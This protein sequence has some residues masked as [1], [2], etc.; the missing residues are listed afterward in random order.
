MWR[1]SVRLVKG[2]LNAGTMKAFSTNITKNTTQSTSGETLAAER[3]FNDA[4]QL[5]QMKDRRDDI[6]HMS[7]VSADD[8]ITQQH[9]VVCGVG[10][11]GGS[12]IQ[13]L[14]A[15]GFKVECIR[16][17]AMPYK[18]E[19][20]EIPTMQFSGLRNLSDDSISNTSKVF[21]LCCKPVHFTSD[22]IDQLARLIRPD[23][24]I[25]SSIGVV[26]PDALAS[27]LKHRLG[28]SVPVTGVIPTINMNLLCA[29][30]LNERSQGIL[31]TL[32]KSGDRI[33]KINV[34]N[35]G[36]EIVDNACMPGLLAHAIDV[37]SL[38]DVH[39]AQSII[40]AL[41]DIVLSDY[42][43][44]DEYPIISDVDRNPV[45]TAAASNLLSGM[46]KSFLRHG[47]S[48]YA[49]AQIVRSIHILKE[50]CEEYQYDMKEI[51]R[52]VTGNN[53]PQSMTGQGISAGDAYL[54]TNPEDWA[55][56]FCAMHKKSSAV[57][58]SACDA[59]QAEIDW[60]KNGKS[61]AMSRNQQNIID[62][63]CFRTLSNTNIAKST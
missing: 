39:A 44:T 17:G 9:A 48:V 40:G 22:F 47:D 20:K 18:I 61:E 52:W 56:M 14:D 36:A 31:Q 4:A 2:L 24:I 57:A 33:M 27:M 10:A 50:L 30:N 60:G 25:I 28:Y 8:I 11:I 62:G 63:A 49:K 13:K 5:V 34:A 3:R 1:Q 42:C 41:Y 6:A 59:T 51:V 19:D 54:L 23:S 37:I 38:H 16:S 12:F 15:N 29:M 45:H 43:S 32:V 26:N 35:R 21:I 55:E 53:N 7:I 46:Y 58:V